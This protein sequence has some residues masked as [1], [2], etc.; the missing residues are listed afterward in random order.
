[1]VGWCEDQPSF[2]DVSLS[3]GSVRRTSTE[4]S[5]SRHENDEFRRLLNLVRSSNTDESKAIEFY[6]SESEL[7]VI[8]VCFSAE[9]PLGLVQVS[10]VADVRSRVG[11]MQN[12]VPR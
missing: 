12:R 11:A 5:K 7:P 4:M 9:P 8:E 10:Q 3:A 2:D 1:M 6:G